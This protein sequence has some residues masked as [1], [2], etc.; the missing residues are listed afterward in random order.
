[1]TGLQEQASLPQWVGRS[2]PALYFSVGLSILKK[3]HWNYREWH[4]CICIVYVENYK[5][6]GIKVK[7]YVTLIPKSVTKCQIQ[8]QREARS[9]ISWIIGLPFVNN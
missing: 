6:F 8:R 2:K 1:M 9:W 4:K 5:H 7:S 3:K